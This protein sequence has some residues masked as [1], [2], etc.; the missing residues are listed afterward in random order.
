MVKLLTYLNCFEDSHQPPHFP[1]ADIVKF[2]DFKGL[3]KTM[4]NENGI[5]ERQQLSLRFA[6]ALTILKS[7]GLT[8]SKA[9]VGIGKSERAPGAHML[10]SAESN[11]Y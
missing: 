10:Q 5:L 1:I 7:Q 3:S 9:W 11:N 8:L 4:K 2:D 6:W